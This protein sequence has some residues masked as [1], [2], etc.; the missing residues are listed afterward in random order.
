MTEQ[1]KIVVIGRILLR[2]KASGGRELIC[3]DV[4]AALAESIK[5][6]L[7]IDIREIRKSLE[8][9]DGATRYPIRRHST[10]RPY[11]NSWALRRAAWRDKE[12]AKQFPN[13]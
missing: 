4:D 10:S 3:R 2:G 7:G 13:C 9:Y 6:V 8:E 5:S 12:R 11:D 1:E